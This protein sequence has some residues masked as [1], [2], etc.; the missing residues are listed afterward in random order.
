MVDGL[1]IWVSVLAINFNAICCQP[2]STLFCNECLYLKSPH[3]IAPMTPPL[4]PCCAC[5][6]TRHFV[7]TFIAMI[8]SCLKKSTLFKPAD[9]VCCCAERNKQPEEHQQCP[10]TVTDH[11]LSC[12]C[13]EDWTKTR[14][15][16]QKQPEHRLGQNCPEM[17][18]RELT[19]WGKSHAFSLQLCSRRS[20]ARVSMEVG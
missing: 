19:C 8:S 6:A 14:P 11:P 17:Q 7:A 12:S 4:R 13:Q 1:L 9:A 3:R 5:S 16:A 10:S 18:V 20:P 2:S 15:P